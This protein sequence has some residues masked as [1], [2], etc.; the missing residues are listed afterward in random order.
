MLER[1]PDPGA[2]LSEEA[3]V[4][5]PNPVPPAVSS[6]LTLASQK[7]TPVKPHFVL[8]APD[9]V[10]VMTF[11]C[12]HAHTQS[13]SS[14]HKKTPSL[15]SPVRDGFLHDPE[16]WVA[17]ATL[18]RPRRARR[19]Y[20]HLVPNRMLA[21]PLGRM[22]WFCDTFLRPDQSPKPRRVDEARLVEWRA[23]RFSSPRPRLHRCVSSR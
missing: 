6:P 5:G 14:K 22:P 20:P 11:I 13:S 17:P 16:G 4:E 19:V 18:G 8:N 9:G 3:D 12:T 23:S 21:P 15:E 1:H 2:E 7:S 10:H